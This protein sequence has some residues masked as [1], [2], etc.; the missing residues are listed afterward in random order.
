M[1]VCRICKEIGNKNDQE[2]GRARETDEGT[3]VDMG[4]LERV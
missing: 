4:L 1:C 3:I 2:K